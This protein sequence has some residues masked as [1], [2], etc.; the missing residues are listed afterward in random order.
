MKICFNLPHEFLMPSEMEPHLQKIFKGKEYDVPFSPPK[1]TILDLGANIG[2]FS[3]WAY[4]RWP[5]AKIFA[6]E[7]HPMNYARLKAN[8][9]HYPVHTFN[10]GIGRPGLRVLHEGKHNCGEHSFHV[11]MNNPAP[12][13]QHIEVRDPLELPEA[14]IIKLDIEGCEMEVL[15]PLITAGRKFKLVLAEYHN[16]SLRR[17]MD[18]ILGD[19]VLVGHDIQ[20]IAGRGVVRYVHKMEMPL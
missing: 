12:T 16:H 7:P 15:E 6:Y 2:A 4:Y 18:M 9:V 10:W 14:D 13:G 11:A 3:I 1:P 8:L 5:E 17:Q 19:Y 20:H